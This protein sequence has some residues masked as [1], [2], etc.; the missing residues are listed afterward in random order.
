MRRGIAFCATLLLASTVGC[1]S[2]AGIEDLKK[3][4]EDGKGLGAECAATSECGAGLTCAA[5]S[6]LR[7]CFDLASPT[8]TC[9]A[10]ACI[11]LDTLT[12]AVCFP[13]GTNVS[14]PCSVT[15]DCAPGFSCVELVAGAGARCAH[16]CHSD[17]R[18]CGG[19]D[20]CHRFAKPIQI[21]GVEFGICAP[22]AT[23]GTSGGGGS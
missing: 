9:A 19:S 6:C 1:A 13:G 5:G 15:T 20:V 21:D 11:P 2:V 22:P 14:E 7:N 17:G 10:D 4:G 23:S 8:K 16:Y 12:E 3:E 18:E